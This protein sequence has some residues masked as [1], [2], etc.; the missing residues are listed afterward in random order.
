MKIN[1]KFI[2]ILIILFI[3]G[4]LLGIIIIQRNKIVQLKSNNETNID[5]TL[6]NCPFC[7]S[8]VIIQPINKDFYIKCENCGLRTTFFN[9]K[10]ELIKYWNNRKITN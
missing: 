5:E 6:Y 4:F 3:V 8:N 9:S 7:N 2:K 1:N 10:K